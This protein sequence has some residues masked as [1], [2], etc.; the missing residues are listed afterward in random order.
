MKLRLALS[1]IF[2][3]VS[4]L[5]LVYAVWALSRSASI[6]SDAIE[7]GQITASDNLYEIVS[8]YMV[9]SGHYFAFAL[10][11]AGIGFLFY[12]KDHKVQNDMP[13]QQTRDESKNS[14]DK[15]T[16]DTELGEWFEA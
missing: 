5:F 4:S 1:I 13:I 3:T 14:L 11:L 16:N 8:F 10:I 15:T 6:I 2:Y 7:M 9:N 12:R